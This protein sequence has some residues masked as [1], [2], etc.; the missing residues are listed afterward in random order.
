MPEEENPGEIPLLQT[1]Q[2]VRVFRFEKEEKK[3]KHANAERKVVKGSEQWK[4]PQSS[5]SV[6]RVI[7][8]RQPNLVQ[9]ET[10][11]YLELRWLRN[12]EGY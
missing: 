9:E 4:D 1:G 6:E 3:S 5:M 12:A 8:E 10:H 7:G 11:W 2:D